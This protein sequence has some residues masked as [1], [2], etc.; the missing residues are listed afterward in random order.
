MRQK[1]LLFVVHVGKSDVNTHTQIHILS[2]KSGL[3]SPAHWEGLYLS[4]LQSGCMESESKWTSVL[5]LFCCSLYYLVFHQYLEAYE[6]CIAANITKHPFEVEE[7]QTDLWRFSH[8]H[9]S[10]QWINTQQ[11]IHRVFQA[12]FWLLSWLKLD[13]H[14]IKMTYSAQGQRARFGTFC[15]LKSSDG[16]WNYEWWD[17]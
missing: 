5:L 12:W 16:L 15:L 11:Y 14:K 7:R 8:S 3:I 1:W 13:I 17:G 6:I 4:G 10:M 9:V 2:W